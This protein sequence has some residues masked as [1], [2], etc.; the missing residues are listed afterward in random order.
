VAEI[1]GDA[2]G[3]GFADVGIGIKS[4]ADPALEDAFAPERLA[5]DVAGFHTY[6]VNWR[7]D[8][9]R[10]LVDGRQIRRIHQA[11]DYPLQLELGVFQF[12]DRPAGPD[13]PEIPELVVSHVRVRSSPDGEVS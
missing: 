5:L 4:F 2:I 1:F 10:F 12:P 8:S 11:P 13:D 9:V 6:A 7:P 3:D